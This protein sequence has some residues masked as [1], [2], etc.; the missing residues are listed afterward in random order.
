MAI[1]HHQVIQIKEA[2]KRNFSPSGIRIKSDK[3]YFDSFF[4]IF[5]IPAKQSSLSRHCQTSCN[6]LYHFP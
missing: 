4:F 1:C 3:N 2:V 6:F 5:I